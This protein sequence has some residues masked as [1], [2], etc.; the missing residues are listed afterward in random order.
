MACK[1]LCQ[2][3]FCF[4]VAVL[5]NMLYGQELLGT[6]LLHIQ[7]VQAVGGF[8]GAIGNHVGNVS[9]RASFHLT[10]PS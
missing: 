7:Y 2:T 3:V 1:Y 9:R 4:L 6:S 8:L 5:T 10:N